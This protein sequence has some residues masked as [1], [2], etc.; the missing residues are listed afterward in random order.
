MRKKESEVK[1]REKKDK[2]KKCGA[3]LRI[4]DGRK[5]KGKKGH[6]KKRRIKKLKG[7]ENLWWRAKGGRV[8]ISI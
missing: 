1:K 6:K 7:E 5:K 8:T 3:Y 2:R 4:D